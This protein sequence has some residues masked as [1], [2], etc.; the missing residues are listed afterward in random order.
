MFII[1]FA[2]FT[3]FYFI[4]D[5]DLLE[6]IGNARDPLVVQRH[7]NKLFA[8]IYSLK[9]ETENARKITAIVYV[10]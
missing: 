2:A 5:E 1:S 4:G 10:G 9:T 7:L 8:G 3:R 6:M